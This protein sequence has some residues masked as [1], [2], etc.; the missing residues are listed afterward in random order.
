MPRCFLMMLTVLL[1]ALPCGADVIVGIG[2][3]DGRAL[4]GEL[5]CVAC[6]RPTEAQLDQL[7][8]RPSPVLTAVGGR[9]T[10]QSLR[11]WLSD[12]QQAKPGTSMPDMLAST[13][14]KQ[15]TEQV[16]DLVHYLAS[17]GGP[18]PQKP[19]GVTASVIEQGRKLYHSVGCV[20]CHEPFDP[21]PAPATEAA[22]GGYGGDEPAAAPTIERPSV[23]LGDLASKTT[24]PKLAAFLR[25]P[26]HTR[27]SGAMPSLRLSESEAHAL[28]VY[29][30]R[31]QVDRSRTAL[32]RGLHY[33]LF[34]GKWASVEAMVKTR[35]VASGS[36]ETFKAFPG[37]RRDRFGVRY[38]GFIEIPADG[39]YV[40]H[41]GSDDGSRLMIDGKPVVDND[42]VHAHVVQRGTI[43]LTKGDHAIEILFFENAGSESLTLEWQRNGK[44]SFKQQPVP[45]ERLKHLSIAMQPRGREQI[46]LD[47]VRIDRG[48]KLFASLGCAA[49]H[50]LKE[51]EAVVASTL[52]AKPLSKLSVD[53]GCLAAAPRGGAADFALGDSQR[54]RIAESLEAL[55][56]KLT[57]RSD[58]KRLHGAMTALNCYACHQ[59]GELG[60]P[61]PGR[62]A[63]FTTTKPVDMGE[64]GRLPPHLN[65]TGAKLTEKGFADLLV[66]GKVRRPH[67]ATRMPLFGEARVRPIIDLLQKVDGGKIAPRPVNANARLVEDGRRLVGTDGF[68][69]INCHSFGN[70]DSLGIP[71]VNLLGVAERLQSGW[72]HTYMRDPAALRPGTRMPAFWLDDAK[73][74]LPKV[75]GGDRDRQI[76]AIWAFLEAGQRGGVPVG[77]RRNEKLLVP[78]DEPIVFRTFMHGVGSRAIAVGF[79]QRVHAAYDATDMRLALAW[80]GAFIGTSSTWSGRAG[81]YEQAVG[82]NI[83][84]FPDGPTV[85]KLDSMTDAWP[86]HADTGWHFRGYTYDEARVPTFRYEQEK[87][88]VTVLDRVEPKTTETTIELHR[89]L[90]IERKGGDKPLYVRIAVGPDIEKQPDGSYLVAQRELFTVESD[91]DEPCIVRKINGTAELLQPVTG[92]TKLKVVLQW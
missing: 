21:P 17:Q 68:G 77:F 51:G 76:D 20:A 5:N 70:H 8:V 7:D 16:E 1:A 73:N 13:P 65:L 42:G 66:D 48:R 25:H 92:T 34:H 82:S 37:K 28:A 30:L 22:D 45:F 39:E 4:L 2:E 89:T 53:G 55:Q 3:R 88:G 85:A 43:K 61:E 56:G 81:Q 59:R 9:V 19:H 72:F 44:E 74:P 26:T 78:A 14:A 69:C 49:C 47:D 54:M 33:E 36:V 75:Q 90:T 60:G 29:L 24:A 32:A 41:L 31:D 38:R 52:S 62:A 15:K 67:M 6:H 11:A 63:Y 86:G 58:A 87:L 35:P 18:M 91:G 23:P 40:F 12:P 10:T 71:A 80:T 79:P 27:P 46:E 83:V 84:R 57:A 50:E 64:E